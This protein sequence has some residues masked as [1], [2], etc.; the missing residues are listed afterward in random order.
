MRSYIHSS[1][2]KAVFSEPGEGAHQSSQAPLASALAPTTWCRFLAHLPLLLPR[3]GGVYFIA[4][5][6]FTLTPQRN[7]HSLTC[8][9]RPVLHISGRGTQVRSSRAPSREALRNLP[10][11][12]GQMLLAFGFLAPGGP[13]R[14]EVSAAPLGVA[15]SIERLSCSVG[16]TAPRRWLRLPYQEAHR[17]PCTVRGPKGAPPVF[18]RTPT[19]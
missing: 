2:S 19:L 17:T 14:L 5:G 8:L 3:A 15:S 9:R 12:T 7:R 13:G 6:P 1:Q 4:A 11:A 16:Y 10:P 18:R